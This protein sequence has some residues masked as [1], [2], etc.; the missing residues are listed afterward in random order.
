M[1]HGAD[2]RARLLFD[3]A[4]QSDGNGQQERDRPPEGQRH[5]AGGTRP[6]EQELVERTA[7]AQ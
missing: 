3:Q 5:F 1:A 7:L 4:E 6:F 2:E